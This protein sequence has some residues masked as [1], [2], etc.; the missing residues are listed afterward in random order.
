ME[1]GLPL[2]LVHTPQTF[3]PDVKKFVDKTHFAMQ[4]FLGRLCRVVQLP[5][6]LPRA[7]LI[8]VARIHFPELSDEHLELIADLA[9][10]SENYLQTVEAV[11]KLA[12]YIARREGHRRIT[13]SDLEAAASEVIPRRPAST[14]DS[15]LGDR[16]Q[17]ATKK[18][19]GQTAAVT[20]KAPCKA[21]ARELQPSRTEP[22]KARSVPDFS[23]RG[24]G[25]DRVEV[26]LLTVEA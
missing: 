25:I 12:R 5:D 24:G 7:D 9:E 20:L 19:R 3:S 22:A 11:A 13:V 17:P 16:Q 21:P 26:G 23:S 4:Q 6:E 18:T 14:P 10:L 2:A 15:A 8:A 1:T